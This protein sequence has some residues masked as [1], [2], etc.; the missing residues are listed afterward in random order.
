VR[1]VDQVVGVGTLNKERTLVNGGTGWGIQLGLLLRGVSVYVF[2]QKLEQ[3]F[4]WAADRFVECEVPVLEQTFAGI[5]TRKINRA[6][7][8]AI[9]AAFDLTAF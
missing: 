7:I 1:H 6:G 3:W 2:D 8:V 9:K 5:G 4:T